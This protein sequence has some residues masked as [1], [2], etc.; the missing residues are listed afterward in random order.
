VYKPMKAVP[1][2][3][4]RGIAGSL[5]AIALLLGLVSTTFA[6]ASLPVPP[7]N[8]V[9]G[10]VGN[11]FT[12]MIYNNGH[13]TSYS[14]RYPNGIVPVSGGIYVA[15]LG[16]N[17]VLFFPTGSVTATR[18]YGQGSAGNDFVATVPMNDGTGTGV[19]AKIGITSATNMSNP[20]GLAVDSS[21]NLYVTDS[22]HNRVLFFPYNATNGYPDFTATRVY[23]QPDFTT[24][25][26]NRD[27]GAN[28]DPNASCSRFPNAT[29]LSSPAGIVTAL[30]GSFYVVDSYNNRI[31]HYPA[32]DPAKTTENFT[33]DRVYGQ[34][35]AGN[36]F[37]V[38]GCNISGTTDPDTGICS[39][40]ASTSASLNTPM[41][42]AIDSSGNLYVADYGN[43]RI[44]S[45]PAYDPAKTTENFTANK[46]WGQTSFIDNTANQ[47]GTTPGASTLSKPSWIAISPIDGSLFVADRSNSRALHY[48]AP[49]SSWTDGP[50]AD[51]VYG[52]ADF[53]GYIPNRGSRVSAVTLNYPRGVAVAAD[54]SFYVVD[55]FNS[56]VLH[57]SG[58][59]TTA[60]KVYGQG[61]TGTDT[62][63]FT[64]NYSNRTG[65]SAT[66]M[67]QPYGV[68]I[69]SDGSIYVADY[70]NNRVLY[71]P[72]TSGVP[73]TTPTRVYGQGDSFTTIYFNNGASSPSSTSLSY[74]AR[75][76]LDPQG[77]IYVADSANHRVL[78][79]SGT[80]T[81]ADRV[82]GQGADGTSA[83]SF[84]TNNVATT[85]TSLNYPRGVAV[86]PDGSLYVAD[87]SNN[88]VLFFPY[89]ATNGYPD[90]TATRVYGQGDVFTTGTANKGGSVSEI[91]LSSPYGVAVDSQGGI[92]VADSANHRTLHYSGIATTADRVYGQ[93]DVFTTGTANK[94]GSVSGIT[95]SSPYGVAVSPMDGSLFVADSA[96]HRALHYSGIS[97]TADRVYGQGITGTDAAE[98]TTGTA[99]KDGI[100]GNPT[101]A[102]LK[103]PYG[104][105]V[106]PV[107]GGLY[108]ADYNN[109]RVLHYSALPATQVGFTTQ[110]VGAKPG[111]LLTTQPVVTVK[112][113][114]GDTAV[115]F[116][117]T[118]TVAIKSGTGT[119]G[120]TLGGTTTV[121]AVAGVATFSDLTIDLV[122]TGYVL[123]ASATDLTSADSEPFDVTSDFVP[124]VRVVHSS[125][126]VPQLRVSPDRVVSTNPENLVSFS[127][128]VENIGAGKAGDLVIS[129]PVPQGLDVGYL[130][131]ASSG[132]WVKQVS[133]T[134]VTIGLP[135]LEP[136]T[137][138]HGVLVFRPN[139]NAV[140]GTKVAV[141]YSLTYNDEAKSGK[142]L[143]SNSESFAF[144]EAN[145]DESEGAIQRGAAV[146]AIA[147][148]KVSITQ[149]GYLANELVAQW[150]TAPDGTTVSLGTHR[151]N[152][153]GVVTIVVN[154]AGLAGDYAVVGYGN[155]S[156]FTQV[157]ILTV[158]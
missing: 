108:V 155:R 87:T 152:A 89:N 40:S 150:Y 32:Y 126:L 62:A 33:A 121:A 64:A 149:T 105:A 81:T 130:D 10:Q 136:Y 115:G 15:D 88:R 107:D 52:Q 142:S 37:V 110:P 46:V 11:D 82:Y 131:G 12:S 84:Q 119:P 99:N 4:K 147:G 63:E 74:P 31:L 90:F 38:N 8:K 111:E 14:L 92:Y 117:G 104:V 43:N 134:T 9:W 65:A 66:S 120:A 123:T 103:N 67:Y 22:S 48:T 145:S 133:A 69:T 79:Y 53:N 91:T 86:A 71:Y 54:G 24:S 68:T 58:T 114:N 139:A 27:G 153:D 18:V 34:G 55:E 93:G 83:A 129:L 25:T 56:R 72:A 75:V 13:V 158:A 100:G 20:M 30:D 127:F 113:A 26:C 73:A 94:G 141:S 128:K 21:G 1:I 51:R 80:S 143:N 45:Y 19:N 101:A 42:L 36:D 28:S 41:G 6:T 47:G 97:T 140:A 35:T 112:D 95:L 77:G 59:A 156:E 138:A 116:N 102:S 50:A 137:G 148:E 76:E 106:S 85:A 61:I 78:H 70:S 39:A 44:L 17:R 16:N 146:S 151:A 157:N 154:T 23:G 122:G 49:T 132:V 7:A 57:Y 96:N 3:K 125:D 2:G 29:N 124:P 135:N 144:G 118:V 60:D 109:N 5:A 98:F